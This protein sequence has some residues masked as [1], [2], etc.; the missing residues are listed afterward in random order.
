MWQQDE[1]KWYE[2]SMIINWNGWEE[3]ELKCENNM[4]W[5]VRTT[6]IKMWEKHEFKLRC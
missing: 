3:H 4:N 6:W 1:C 5:D 2:N